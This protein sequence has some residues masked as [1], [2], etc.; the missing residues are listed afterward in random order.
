MRR[1][2][3]E[4][5]TRHDVA[6]G[7]EPGEVLFRRDRLKGLYD[8][9]HLFVLELFFSDLCSGPPGWINADAADADEHD[10]VLD[11]LALFLPDCRLR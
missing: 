2:P 1:I 8:L 4:Y 9:L 11:S 5:A 3:A 10:V 6:L 7:S